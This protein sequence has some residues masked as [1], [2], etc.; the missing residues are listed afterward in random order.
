M[1]NKISDIPE[2]QFERLLDYSDK[3]QNAEA[4]FRAMHGVDTSKETNIVFPYPPQKLKDM[5][6]EQIELS[7]EEWDAFWEII[8]EE[9]ANLA[10]AKIEAI[11]YNQEC[12]ELER[13]YPTQFDKDGYAYRLKTDWDGCPYKDYI[14]MGG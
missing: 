13:Q 1:N 2:E 5:R 8:R 12:E 4:D 6:K 3:L 9:E 11:K 7:G 10:K 14:E